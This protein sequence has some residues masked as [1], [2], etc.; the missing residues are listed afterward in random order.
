VEGCYDEV[1]EL[2]ASIIWKKFLDRTRNC[3]LFIFDP[4][5]ALWSSKPRI[6]PHNKPTKLPAIYVSTTVPFNQPK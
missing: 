5:R 1:I 3:W 4:E 2:P 6:N